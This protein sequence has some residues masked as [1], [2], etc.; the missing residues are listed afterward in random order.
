M[1]SVREGERE[2]EAEEV[3][4]TRRTSISLEKVTCLPAAMDPAVLLLFIDKAP[5]CALRM[6]TVR[7]QVSALSWWSDHDYGL[8]QL[9]PDTSVY[10][11]FLNV[12][13]SGGHC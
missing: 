6:C 5:N 4:E 2:R 11:S 10:W 9:V 1:E 12:M 3:E 13:L 8:F 7:G